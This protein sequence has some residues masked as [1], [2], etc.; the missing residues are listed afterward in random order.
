[1]TNKDPLKKVND[2]RDN[3]ALKKA[4]E[5]IDEARKNL[6]FVSP[7]HDHFNADSAKEFLR[8]A[9]RMVVKEQKRRGT[10]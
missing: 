6:D 10:L 4:V 3:E 7:D 5:H 2:R 8:G 1:M 9:K